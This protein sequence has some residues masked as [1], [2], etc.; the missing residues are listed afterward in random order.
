MTDWTV[1]KGESNTTHS[2]E[3]GSLYGEQFNQGRIKLSSKVR[4]WVDE[5]NC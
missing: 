4:A 1:E 5:M 3:R 2:T